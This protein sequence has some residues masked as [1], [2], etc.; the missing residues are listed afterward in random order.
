MVMFPLFVGC[1]HQYHHYFNITFLSFRHA[2]IDIILSV[3][4]QVMKTFIWYVRRSIRQEKYLN[5][6]NYLPENFYS[7]YIFGK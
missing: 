2:E 3:E 1:L 5:F 4:D 6:G 7:F